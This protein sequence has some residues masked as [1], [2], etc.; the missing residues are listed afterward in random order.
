MQPY[1]GLVLFSISLLGYIC[2]PDLDKSHFLREA[3]N[4]AET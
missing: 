2:A 4:E 3:L 1:S